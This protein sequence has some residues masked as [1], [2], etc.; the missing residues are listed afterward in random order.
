MPGFFK[1]YKWYWFLLI[2]LVALIYRSAYFFSVR[3]EPLFTTPV[4]DGEQHHELAKKV[5]QGLVLGQGPEEVFKPPLYPL[6]L[7]GIYYLGGAQVKYVQILQFLLGAISSV[8]IALLGIFLFDKKTG[9]LAGLVFALYAPFVFFEGQLLTPSLQILL[10]LI[11]TLILIK[12]DQKKN[13]TWIILGFI[14][15]VSAGFRPDVIIPLF[16]LYIYYFTKFF[17]E[18]QI[19]GLVRKASFLLFGFLIIALPITIRNYYLTGEWILFSSNAGINFYT[20][21]GPSADGVSAINTGLAWEQAISS[22]PSSLLFKPTKVSRLWFL[23]G[24]SFIKQNPFRWLKLIGIKILAFFNGLEFRNNIGFNYFRKNT[25]Y[26][27]IPFIQYWLI[28]SFTLLTFLLLSFKKIFWH[29]G[30]ILPLLLITGYLL[31]GIIFFVNAR[32]RL[33]AVP[34]MILLAL[35]G[36]WWIIK[37][38]TES[39][40]GIF[41]IVL[42]LSIIFVITWSGWFDPAKGSNNQDFINEGNIWRNRGKLPEALE[43]YRLAYAM[44][45]NEP[46]GWFLAGYTARQMGLISEAINS[47]QKTLSII[48]EA[49]DVRL[50]LADIYFQQGEIE[51]AEH[52]YKAIVQMDGQMNLWHKRVSVA[53][54][55]LGLFQIYGFGKEFDKAQTEI[56]RAWAKEEHTVAEYCLMNNL[57]IERAVEAFKGFVE[58]EPWNWYPKA[59][60]GLAYLKLGQDEQAVQAFSMSVKS[61]GA[62]SRVSLHLALALLKVG[63]REEGRKVID[64]LISGLAPNDPTRPQALQI[65]KKLDQ[66]ENE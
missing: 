53:K 13:L 60:L 52:Q 64:N 30:Y 44:D 51:K 47:F 19:R 14:T 40:K 28:S 3:N 31:T 65:L 50:N 25:R 4:I 26:L 58:E 32:F 6:L 22:I 45:P 48:P 1:K 18:N 10:N 11:I 12:A 55:Y 5:S 8:L 27:K 54:A 57:Y 42:V 23:R 39:W 2:F 16:L 37:K 35:Q 61:K 63:K 46:D 62:P 20:G 29:K 24:L 38:T 34:F 56:E 7:G 9:L 43:S 66:S 21:N 36:L 41:Q 49:I 17:K 59:N 33:P 15:G